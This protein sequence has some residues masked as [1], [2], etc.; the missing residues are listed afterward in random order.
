MLFLDLYKNRHLLFDIKDNLS[1]IEIAEK[2][3]QKKTRIFSIEY[4]NQKSKPK[5]KQ[6]LLPNH[7]NLSNKTIRISKRI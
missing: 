3:S 7:H 6:T 5:R 1:G 2:P 4:Q